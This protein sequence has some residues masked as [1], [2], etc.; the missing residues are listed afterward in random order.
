MQ[1]EEV[2]SISIAALEQ[3]NIHVAIIFRPTQL[4]ARYLSDFRGDFV[5]R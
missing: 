1:V 3:A 4:A 2:V 5:L